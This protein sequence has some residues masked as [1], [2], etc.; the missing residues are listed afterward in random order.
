MDRSTKNLP[1]LDIRITKTGTK[2]WIDVYNK[3][4]DSKRLCLLHQIT[5]ELASEIFN[6]VRLDASALLLKKKT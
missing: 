6:F 2:I 5:P 3:P 4:T 1:F